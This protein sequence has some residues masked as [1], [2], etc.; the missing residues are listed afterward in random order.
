MPTVSIDWA[1]EWRFDGYDSKGMP[2]DVDGRQKLGSK[3]SDLLPMALAA[4]S[5]TDLVM[6]LD[7]AEG[8]TLDSL[9]VDATYTQQP[10]PPWTFRRIR[11]H[12][13][14]SGS[15]LTDLLVSDAIRRSEEELCSVAASLRPTV[16]IE[17][18]FQILVA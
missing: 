1:G 12:Y 7:E 10:D 11:L 15:G 17:S 4:C 14:L 6:L 3:P 16:Q 8:I 18:T 2:V 5:G 9:S 13:R